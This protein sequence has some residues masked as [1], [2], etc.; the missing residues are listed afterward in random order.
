MNRK[1]HNVKSQIA[2]D[3]E[4]PA[5]R[6]RFEVDYETFKIAVQILLALEK[7][8]WTYQDLAKAIGTNKSHISRDLKSGGIESASVSRIARIA[9]ALGMTFIPLFIANE[10]RKQILPKLHGLVAA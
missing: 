10:K 9:D 1:W 2:R 6:K 5:Y 7:K 3:L 4:N 8:N